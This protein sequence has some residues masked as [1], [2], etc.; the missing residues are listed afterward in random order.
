MRDPNRLSSRRGVSEII[1]MVLILAIVLVAFVATSGLWFGTLA[2]SSSSPK[3]ANVE[4]DR[5][6]V[7]AGI[8]RGTTYVFCSAGTATPA[9]A[10]VHLYNTGTVTTTARLVS[11]S[12][13][14]KSVPIDLTGACAVAPETGMFLAIISLPFLATT[15]DRYTGYVSFANGAEVEFAGAFV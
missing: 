7:P 3:P 12:Y 15:G 10:Y 9:G 4:V 14:G 6:V 8:D 1:A 13:G 11:F 2:W 5:Q